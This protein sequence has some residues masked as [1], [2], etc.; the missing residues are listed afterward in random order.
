MKTEQF[1]N[2][3]KCLH[4]TPDLP[5]TQEEKFETTEKPM[6]KKTC[7]HQ[8]PVPNEIHNIAPQGFTWSNNSHAYDSSLVI[9]FVLWCSNKKIWTMKFQSMGNQYIDDLVNGFLDVDLNL[10]T[11]E[12]VRDDIRRKFDMFFPDHLQ[13]GHFT[14]L[15]DVL[16]VILQANV[17]VR[18]SSY[19]CSNNHVQRI[20][21]KITQIFFYLL[22]HKIIH[23]FHPGHQC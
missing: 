21:K 1:S 14:S 2:K 15:D 23:Q 17:P 4:E 19:V 7:L 20:N 10:K 13:F 3:Q 12:R 22:E 16:E 9:L 8:S 6:I 5:V 11:L 18:S